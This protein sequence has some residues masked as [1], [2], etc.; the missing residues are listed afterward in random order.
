MILRANSG[1]EALELTLRHNFALVILD[2]QMPEMDG[3]AVAQLLR[4]DPTTAQ[5]PIIFVSA[6]YSNEQHQFDGYDVG[7][8]DY[9]VKPLVPEVLLAKVR[10]FLELASYRLGLEAQVPERTEDLVASERRR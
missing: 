5:M 8:V 3:Y 7:A 10:V 1:Q 4:S 6:T 2:V 9:I